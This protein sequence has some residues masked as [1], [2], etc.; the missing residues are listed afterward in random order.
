MLALKFMIENVRRLGGVVGA[1]TID[2]LA[3]FEER[4]RI[5]ALGGDKPGTKR[6]FEL[7][8]KAEI[9]LVP[10]LEQTVDVHLD[11]AGEE[12]DLPF[13]TCVFEPIETAWK[14]GAEAGIAQW[15]IAC[16]LVT[17][18]G[19]RKYEYFVMLTTDRGDARV[20]HITSDNALYAA[21]LAT[22]VRENLK[23]L[24]RCR[25]G[26]EKVKERVRVGVGKEE[27]RIHTIRR[28]L[29]IVPRKLGK[30]VK[31]L[32]GRSVEFSHRWSV[33]GTWVTFWKDDAKT[34]IDMSRIGKDRN[35]DYC[36]R[37]HTW[38]VEHIKGPEDK[39]LIKKT[40]VVAPD[41][42]QKPEGQ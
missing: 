19:P 24:S 28:V 38:R 18:I 37:G 34:E 4:F 30:T 27:K 32:F 39:P 15:E 9:F 5:A 14:M 8:E 20:H 25:I 22:L 16:A 41:E 35:G 12:L 26:E 40:R 10:P 36:V 17:E 42:P 31:P 23:L 29:R 21:H 1:Y 2:D 7:V 33:R 6:F 3:R 13:Q 11:A